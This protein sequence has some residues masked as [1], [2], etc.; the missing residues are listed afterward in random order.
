[1]SKV[2]FMSIFR[3][4]GCFETVFEM[5]DMGGERVRD[6]DGSI[7]LEGESLCL[8]VFDDDFCQKVEFTDY[9]NNF[10]TLNYNDPITMEEVT[11]RFKFD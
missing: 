3:N 9:K 7:C 8:R 4:L 11:V 2:D 6:V 10:V 5:K 1:M